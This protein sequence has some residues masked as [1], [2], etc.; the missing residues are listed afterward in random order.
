MRALMAS[1]SPWILYWIG[2]VRCRVMRWKISPALGAA[3]SA[4]STA[5]QS[6]KSPAARPIAVT[7]RPRSCSMRTKCRPIK[8]SLPSTIAG[9][10][11]G[12]VAVPIDGDD[13]AFVEGAERRKV[14]GGAELSPGRPA[15]G[16]ARRGV[17]CDHDPLRLAA[18][19]HRRFGERADGDGLA[20]REVVGRM[21]AAANERGQKDAC[22]VACEYKIALGVRVAANLESIA[23]S[24]RA[25][26]KGRCH[27]RRV[28]VGGIEGTVGI[29]KEI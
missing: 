7:G 28:D 12:G 5:D 14:E 23:G 25:H 4:R 18:R 22:H 13:E 17:A 16:N 11:G 26:D 10:A 2:P 24:E 9:S 1:S 20:G 19:A 3:A 6:A 27:V 8:P 15:G 29:G 21:L